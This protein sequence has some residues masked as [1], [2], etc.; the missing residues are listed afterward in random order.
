MYRLLT[1]E[2]KSKYFFRQFGWADLLASLPLPHFKVL[3]I[4]RLVRVVRLLRR[5]GGRRIVRTLLADRAGSALFTLVT[6]GILVLEFGSL[7][8]PPHRAVRGGCQHHVGVRL[9]VVRHGDHLDGRLPRP[10]R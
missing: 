6:M 3:R 2:S 5:N 9:L 4:F 7:R 8:D 1:A 10:L